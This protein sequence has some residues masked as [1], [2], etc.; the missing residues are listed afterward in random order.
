MSTQNNLTFTS[1]F[2][3]QA[4]LTASFAAEA[5]FNESARVTFS[6]SVDGQDPLQREVEIQAGQEFP[7]GLVFLRGTLKMSPQKV[8]T[9]S[10][11][12]ETE[13]GQCSISD[14]IITASNS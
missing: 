6:V 8:I 1:V 11:N 7:I 13:V 14:A 10:G 3:G 2:K 5:S 4:P 9:F 12:I